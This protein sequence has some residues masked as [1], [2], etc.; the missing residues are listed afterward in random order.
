MLAQAMMP[1]LEKEARERQ[2]ESG[3]E[4]GRV[5]PLDVVGK[6]TPS[7]AAI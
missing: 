2:P 1:L 6:S 7:G 4:F 3:L 5:V